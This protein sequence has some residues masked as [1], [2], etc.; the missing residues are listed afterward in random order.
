MSF[1]IPILI[2]H[3]IKREIQ[4]MINE[5]KYLRI[6]SDAWSDLIER[7]I[8][9]VSCDLTINDHIIKIM[10]NAFFYGGFTRRG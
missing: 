10:L 2:Y 5:I 8:I 3:A 9:E 4:T 1:F 7:Y 6:Q